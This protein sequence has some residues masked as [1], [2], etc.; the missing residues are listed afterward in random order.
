MSKLGRVQTVS[1]H[2]LGTQKDPG[3]VVVDYLTDKKRADNTIF[4]TFL[5][6]QARIGD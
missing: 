5:I 1:E 3:F 6:V 4:K 2:L